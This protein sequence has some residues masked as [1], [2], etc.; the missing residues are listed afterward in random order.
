[1]EDKYINN[2]L[3]KFFIGFIA[4]LGIQFFYSSVSF[5]QELS[6]NQYISKVDFSDIQGKSVQK[7]V[8]GMPLRTTV[9]LDIPAQTF[10]KSEVTGIYHLPSELVTMMNED[11]IVYNEKNE[12]VGQMEKSYSGDELITIHLKLPDH[13]QQQRLHVSFLARVRE[14]QK[15]GSRDLTVGDKAMQELVIEPATPGF[16][17]WKTDALNYALEERAAPYWESDNLIM[18]NYFYGELKQAQIKAKNKNYKGQIPQYG[19]PYFFFGKSSRDGNYLPNEIA[20][21]I[22]IFHSLVDGNGYKS[23]IE[24]YLDRESAKYVVDIIHMGAIRAEQNGM[25]VVANPQNK[26]PIIFGDMLTQSGYNQRAY[27]FAAQLVAWQVAAKGNLNPQYRLDNLSISDINPV[28][29]RALNQPYQSVDL[30]NYINELEQ[31]RTAFNDWSF[32]DAYMNSELSTDRIVTLTLPKNQDDFEVYIDYDKS[33]NLDYLVQSYLPGRNVPFKELKLQLAKPLPANKN[34]KLVFYKLPKD[35]WKGDVGFSGVSQGN[36]QYKAVYTM[37]TQYRPSTDLPFQKEEDTVEKIEIVGEKRWNDGEHKARPLSIT[38]ILYQNGIEYDRKEVKMEDNWKYT[39][40]DLP[41]YDQNGNLYVYTVKEET[42]PGYSSTVEGTIITNTKLTDIEGEKIWYDNNDRNRPG[43]IVVHLLQNGTRID[44]QT[45]TSKNNWKYV[46]TD[47][48]SFDN[49][50]NRY[51]YTVE[52]EQ[53]SGYETIIDGTTII[54]TKLIAVEGQK[55]WIDSNN[56]DKTRPQE[57]TIILLQNNQEYDRTTVKPDRFGNWSYS[58]KNLPMYDQ[59]GKLYNYSVKEVPV[60]EYESSV[61]GTTITNTQLTKL[62]GEKKWFDG[63]G[64]NRPNKITVRLYRKVSGSVLGATAID[65]QE[66]TVDKNWRYSFNDLPKYNSS[67]KAYEYSV[68]EDA[69]PGYETVISPDSQVISNYADTQVVG[70]KIWEDADNQ[71]NTRPQAITV[72]LLQNGEVY[73]EKQV[74]ADKTGKWSYRFDKLPMYDKKTN[75]LYVYTVV[76][77]EIPE[78]YLMSVSD[79]ISKNNTTIIDITNTYRPTGVLPETGSG[80]MKRRLIVVGSSV[81]ITSLFTAIYLVY[82]SKKQFKR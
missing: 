7:S 77:K 51:E 67:G 1:M 43:S 59:N 52:E 9:H 15:I 33:E 69:V 50:G 3:Y 12:I 4:V 28:M 60:E 82:Q 24:D 22:D 30:T 5:A 20:I 68:K 48:P 35:S 65:K 79:S 61:S 16:F 47:L 73:Q 2:V 44:K 45:V 32:L 72:Q 81:T 42:I 29:R 74:T 49:N 27:M 25:E 21:C 62:E 58:F 38:I 34:V 37:P 55:K 46:F 56:K 39:F 75:Q 19:A 54:N 41:K 80:K 31:M 10:A 17:G 13:T 53:V 11:V 71:F 36:A 66:V 63:D 64:A 40:T 78:H 57:I 14:M 6:L 76:E 70:E 23:D 26:K 8:I 18:G